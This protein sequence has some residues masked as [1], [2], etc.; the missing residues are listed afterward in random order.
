ME[1]IK[2]VVVLSFCV[3][4]LL[5]QYTLIPDAEFEQKLIT[6]NIDTEGILDGQVL[7]DD[8]DH[9]TLLVLDGNPPV[10]PYIY[11][12]TGIEDFISLEDLRFSNNK[13]EQV[14]LSNL[15]NLKKLLCKFNALTS[16][17]VSNNL[18]L[19]NIDIDNCPPGICDQENTLTEIDVS[20][21]V[22]LKSFLSVHNYFFELDFSNN[23]QLESLSASFNENLISLN[24]KNGNNL[25]LNHFSANEN[26]NLTCIEVDDPVAATNGDIPPYDNWNVQEGAVFSEDCTL[27]VNDNSLAA[28]SIYP[29]PVSNILYINNEGINIMIIEIYDVLGKNVWVTTE[30]TTQIDISNLD[31]GLYLVN[32]QTDQGVLVKKVMKE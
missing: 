15:S 12:L 16:L 2:L 32:I 31:N 11:D 4:S 28:I 18:L 9:I 17:D 3:N 8:I 22:N 5:A 21:N 24:I 27:G 13:V 26:P 25:I 10:T 19:E 30:S 6:Q 7:T 29:N 14:D 23:I 20:N 1:K